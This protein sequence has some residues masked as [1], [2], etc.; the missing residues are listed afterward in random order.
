[1]PSSFTSASLVLTELEG[2][3]SE[4]DLATVVQVFSRLR[5][6][7]T[8]IEMTVEQRLEERRAFLAAMKD[9][10]TCEDVA[11][12]RQDI[13][14]SLVELYPSDVDAASLLRAFS[15]FIG[16]LN[17]EQ[18]ERVIV[19][20]GPNMDLPH[21]ES[22]QEEI[23]ERVEQFGRFLE[24]HSLDRAHPPALITIA[25]SSGDEFLPPHQADSV[26]EA[27]LAVLKRAF[28]PLDRRVIEYDPVEDGDD[29]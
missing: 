10:E 13:V 17:K 23:A 2:E 9:V 7:R 3:F 8:D 4:D 11:L 1:M 22:S 26:L 14:N 12:H 21:H 27:V 18:R 24:T 15:A 19:W 5:Y 29:E 25:K 20:A 28:G 16:A 6:K